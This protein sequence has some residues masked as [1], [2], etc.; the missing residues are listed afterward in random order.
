[1]LTIDTLDVSFSASRQESIIKTFVGDA[2]VTPCLW[3]LVWL[4]SMVVQYHSMKAT[5]NFPAKV[6]ERDCLTRLDFLEN[7]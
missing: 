2:R 3:P 1:M 6:A 4:Q 5:F 7:M